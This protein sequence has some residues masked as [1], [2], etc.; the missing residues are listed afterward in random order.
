MLRTEPKKARPQDAYKLARE[1]DRVQEQESEQEKYPLNH[2]DGETCLRM[3]EVAP[4][5]TQEDGSGRRIQK[6]PER[7]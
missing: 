6:A 4:K 1:S 2:R 5:S 7:Q 3:K